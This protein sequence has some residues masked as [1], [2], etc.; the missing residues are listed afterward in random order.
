MIPGVIAISG[1]VGAESANPAPS[2]VRWRI[3][4]RP[5]AGDQQFHIKEL[6]LSISDVGGQAAI[7][8]TAGH[9][10]ASTTES[11]PANYS[12]AQ[13]FDE[14][15]GGDGWLSEDSDT[16]IDQWL[17]FTFD[18]STEITC[19]TIYGGG[20]DTNP[21]DFD[22][23]YH[24]G[25]DWVVAET[26]VL[27]ADNY[28]SDVFTT[29]VYDNPV[30]AG[31]HRYWRILIHDS[32]A[33]SFYAVSELEFRDT[34]GGSDLTGSGTPISGGEDA[35]KT[36]DQAF[37]D[38][39]FTNEWR[40][41]VGDFPDADDHWI[42]YDFGSGNAFEIIEIEMS[43]RDGTNFNQTPTKF[44][45]Q[46][47]D[48]T[49]TWTTA[50]SVDF[51][52]PGQTSWTVSETKV[53][54]DPNPEGAPVGD[55]ISATRWRLVSQTTGL[56][57]IWLH[58]IEFRTEEGT[59]GTID[60]E[61]LDGTD[62]SASASEELTSYEADQAFNGVDSDNGWSSESSPAAGVWIEF[63]FDTS[64]AAKYV[65]V[66]GRSAYLVTDWDVEYHNGSSW[67][68][69][70]SFNLTDPDDF[71]T[72]DVTLDLE[73]NGSPPAPA[74]YRYWR[75]RC[76]DS[77]DPDYFSVAEIEMRETSGQADQATSGQAISGAEDDS[78]T[79]GAAFDNDN[80]T[81]WTYDYGT[82]G[83]INPYIGQDFGDGNDKDITRIRITA[84]A[85]ANAI[86]C[87]TGFV[88]EASEAG[89]VWVGQSWVI[90]GESFWS[91]GEQRTFVK[92]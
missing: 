70:K 3:Y 74:G 80:A 60:Q 65:T 48:D 35:G 17:E 18:N 23:Q 22:L 91:A 89:S 34:L 71:T 25:D 90:T 77:N 33:G 50:W 43:A 49:V 10:S 38:T 66:R 85:G 75:V 81:N 19:F 69:Q 72:N 5:I 15:T 88:V 47:S 56:S 9:G 29:C 30:A 55:E 58:E 84:P 16:S 59:F 82:R 86:R 79:D 32:D 92:P 24:D 41:T 11:S 42:G 44:D 37:D 27:I 87:P 83:K 73:N 31:L 40:L 57:F 4:M 51:A 68:L 14:V 1:G 12:A 61:A 6:E 20:G 67:V 78:T 46:Y 2:A 13:A 63:T 45:V 36:D 39:Y 8:T 62:G 54:S 64:Y 28:I 7:E 53:F 52:G 26:F 76:V 21:L